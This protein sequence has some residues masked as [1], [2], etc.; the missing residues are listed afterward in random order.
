MRRILLALIAALCVAS[1]AA[2]QGVS[3]AGRLSDGE[4][5]EGI[6][7]AVIELVPVGSNAQNPRYYTSEYGGNFRFT[8]TRAGSYR[9]TAT[10]LGY[11]PREFTF[12]VNALPLN[13]GNVA[14]KPSAV[15]IDV[16]AVQGVAT[17]TTMVGDT[18]RYNADAFKV[19]T[20]AEVEAL[21]RKMP[22]ITITDGRIEAHG[23]VVKQIYVDGAEFFG[24]NLQQVLQSIPAQA[25]EHIEVY[26]RLS[27][28]AQITGVDDGEGGKAINIVTRQS[29][30]RSS[31][32]KLFAGVGYEPD[33]QRHI[34]SKYKYTAGG[35]VNMFRDDMRLTAMALV[36]NINKQNLT[37]EGMSVSDKS[38][39]SNASRQ[40]S[41]NSQAGVASAEIFAL[42]YSDRWGARRR[43]R[44]DGNVFYNHLNARNDY[45]IDRWYERPAKI[46][47]AHYDQFANPNNHTLKFRGR[48]EWKV[49]KRQKLVIIPAA[50]Y[51]NNSSVNS[52][53]S[54]S[55]RW[56]E[57]GYRWL[58]SG[59]D[60]S[61]R[62]YSVSTYAQYSYKFLR[63]GRALLLVASLSHSDSDA[64]CNYYSNGAGLTSKISP[65]SATIAYTYSRKLTDTRT[66][67]LRLQ[68]TFRERIG[69]YGT[70]NLSYRLQTQLRRRDLLSYAT[71]S[72]YDTG[73]A[74]PNAKT[75]SS[76]DGR[77][78]YHQANIGFRYSRNRN[79][80]SISA[81]Y[82]N[83]R[84]WNH[85]RWTGE[86][87]LRTYHYPIYNATLQ[88]S[89]SPRNVLRLSCN[90]E[91][92]APSLWTMLDIYDVSNSQ[93]I[94]RGNP[95]LRPFAEHN[96]FAR[97]THLAPA[98]GITF[99][100]MAKAQ[101][102]ADY[103]GTDIIYSPA[104][105]EIDGRKYNPIQ[106]TMPVNLDGCWSYEGR[107]SVGFPVK[108]LGSNLNV[109]L[110]AT[111]A[112][113]PA[114]VNKAHDMMRNLSGYARLTLGSNISENVDFTVDWR[115][116]YST[117][118]S[119]LAV[120]NNNYFTHNASATVKIV[121][122]LGFTLTTSASFTQYVGFT[123][124]YNDCFTMWNAAIGKKV[125]RRL[126]EVQLCV[127]DILN[128]NTSFSRYVW[129]GYSQVRYNTTMGR[130]FMVKFTY[131][132]RNLS[133]GARRMRQANR[134]N[135]APVNNFEAIE[136]RLS[137]L[138]F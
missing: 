119:S 69:R 18:L 9:C 116:S 55:L 128:Q 13:L 35:S 130:C 4:S 89:F 114:V 123:N 24:G 93:Y 73:G 7:G 48:L 110:G 66:T 49:A 136:R 95:D 10:F 135:S 29:L 133:T 5:G 101:H 104:T 46:D 102:T 37:D 106:L 38:N 51:T 71:A 17:R 45:T 79:W 34:S 77:F 86:S 25:V 124:H 64:D 63:Q 50:T 109:A 98:R 22:G 87:R 2:Q 44:F 61:S 21:L 53:D 62:Y 54:T 8:V 12:E 118:R 117:A 39:R 80:F 105:I 43:A 6:A 65:D 122:P 15:G 67:N 137:Q 120:L 11:E 97:Y 121:L 32:G 129:A 94:S 14:M 127:D 20:D 40:F 3:V 84:L 57:S 111:Y 68:P 113:V 16:V 23:E 27:E 60:G 31:F 81:A 82:Q 78:L 108:W 74:K 26:N 52:V 58:P 134:R 126:G 99:M 88:W 85:N 47:T 41:V 91:V 1:V 42:N 138:R 56:G 90:S 103:I 132:L 19:A 115:G 107:A 75:S 72:D 83:S 76:F 131:N 125:L 30:K 70:L 100:L 28:A 92:K 36:N 112:T 33:A 59:N 96:F